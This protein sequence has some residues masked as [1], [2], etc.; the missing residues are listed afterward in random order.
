MTTPGIWFMEKI[1]SSEVEINVPPSS[2]CLYTDHTWLSTENYIL[3]QSNKWYLT[4][5]H[6]SWS[7]LAHLRSSIL[8]KA[9]WEN[10]FTKKPEFTFI[11]HLNKPRVH[12]PL[13]LW[14]RNLWKL[15]LWF[16]S[17]IVNSRVIRVYV[18]GDVAAVGVSVTGEWETLALRWWWGFC[19]G[20][21]LL[22]K[23]LT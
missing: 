3:K 20:S 15:F 21:Q 17:L 4:S 13:N 16:G 1:P 2:A 14:I 6:C 5:F 23:S 11:T 8:L 22:A 10:I 12:M 19:C 9:L 7:H 18:L